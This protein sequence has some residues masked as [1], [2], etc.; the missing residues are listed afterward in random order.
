MRE[1]TSHQRKMHMKHIEK[2]IPPYA[3][4]PVAALLVMGMATYYGTRLLNRGFAHYDLSLPLDR[5]IPFAPW[6]IV[7]YILAYVT[8]VVGYAVIARE[9]KAHCYRIFTAELLAKALTMLCFLLIPTAMVRPDVTGHDPFSILTRLIYSLD[10]PDNL[11]PSIHCLEN[12]M[13]FRGLLGCKKVG[14]GWK[15]AAFLAA[16]AVFASTLL[17]KQHMVAD[18]L[19]AVAVAELGLLLS[20][21]LFPVEKA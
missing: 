3:W 21:W 11:F 8:W 20:A 9:S 4:K 1:S 16:L 18:V 15:L 2:L 13:I 6:A 12:W 5:L 14:R 17:V 7:I 10:Q 19:G